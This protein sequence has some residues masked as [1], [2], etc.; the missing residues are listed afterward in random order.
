MIT[1]ETLNRIVRFRSD[2][3]PVTSLYVRIPRDPRD[4]RAVRSQVDSLVHQIR[5]L[6]ENGSFDHAAMMSLRGDLERIDSVPWEDRRSPGTLAVFS[7][8]GRGFYEQVELPRGVRERVMVDST[9]WVRALLAVL[10][11][12]HR[13]CVVV[14]DKGSARIWELYQKD[15]Y[16]V[17]KIRDRTLRKP[18]YAAGNTE[19]RVRNKADELAKRHYRRVVGQLDELFR[20]D[21]FDVLAIGGHQHEV[22]GFLDFLPRELGARVAGSFTLDAATA[23]LGEIKQHAMD[24]VDRYERDEER[25]QVAEVLDITAAGGRAAVGLVDCLW[26]ATVAAVNHLLVQEDVRTPGVVCDTDGWLARRGSRCPLCGRPARE[27]SD[28]LDE[29][30]QEVIDEGGSVEHVRAA[31]PLT[32]HLAAA[33]LR[34]PLPPTPDSA[35]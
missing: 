27:T 12:Y 23:T 16:E 9:P 25:R 34:F 7:C 19:Y 22:P 15:I 6:A 4:R 28:I 24:I 32:M 14:L 30:V 29:L 3:F 18:N 8:S 31:T 33:F 5:P 1:A 2:E 20:T 21:G 17:I 11:E 26:A 35:G 10:D 13:C